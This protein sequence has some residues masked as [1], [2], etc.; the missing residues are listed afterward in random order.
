MIVMV[1]MRTAMAVV[2]L[3]MTMMTVHLALAQ[4]RVWVPGRSFWKA[5]VA[6]IGED[7]QVLIVL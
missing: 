5:W 6:L 4:E 7:S 3:K 2:M 1:V